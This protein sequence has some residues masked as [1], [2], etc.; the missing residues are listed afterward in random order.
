MKKQY[1]YIHFEL[2][3]SENEL[4]FYCINN[5][6]NKIIGEVTWYKQWKCHVFNAWNDLAIFNV[7]CLEDIVDFMEQLQNSKKGKSSE[8]DFEANTA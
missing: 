5:K 3:S 8:F 2:S 1:K 7:S 4:S 6:S